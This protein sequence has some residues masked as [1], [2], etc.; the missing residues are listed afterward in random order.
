MDKELQAAEKALNTVVKAA[1]GKNDYDM[2]QVKSVCA[3]VAWF[4]HGVQCGFDSR[5]FTDLGM[6]IEQARILLA[7]N[8]GKGHISK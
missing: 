6:T 3:Y 4:L 1:A 5:D 8:I 2:A 7:K